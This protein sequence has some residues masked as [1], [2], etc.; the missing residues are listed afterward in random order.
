MKTWMLVLVSA[1][2]MCITICL[3]VADISFKQGETAGRAECPVCAEQVVGDFGTGVVVPATE[4]FGAVDEGG[5]VFVKEHP[6]AH[7]ARLMAAVPIER[8][9]S[10]QAKVCER[11]QGEI[12]LSRGLTSHIEICVISKAAGNGFGEKWAACER[13]GGDPVRFGGLHILCGL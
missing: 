9:T 10:W 11:V 2:V 1:V 3:I 5:A 13:A 12:W 8:L 6:Q 7:G 4:G